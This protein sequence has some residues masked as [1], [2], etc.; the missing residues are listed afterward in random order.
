[1]TV[2]PH[3]RHGINHVKETKNKKNKAKKTKAMA[4][5]NKHIRDAFARVVASLAQ[6]RQIDVM[7][8]TEKQSR[9][10]LN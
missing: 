3:E 2:V 10:S 1:M 9:L 8:A 4:T 7:I 5:I 6:E